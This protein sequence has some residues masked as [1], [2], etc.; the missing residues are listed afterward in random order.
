MARQFK[1]PLFPWTPVLGAVMSLFLL[2]SL[3]SDQKTRNFFIPYL[4][5]GVVLYFVYGMWNSKLGKGIVV[6][7]HEVMADTPHAKG[8][9]RS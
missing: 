2:M 3:V 5:I 6:H 4:L 8:L 7:G 9:D 1:T